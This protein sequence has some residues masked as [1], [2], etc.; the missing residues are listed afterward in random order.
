MRKKFCDFPYRI[1]IKYNCITKIL[2]S[3]SHTPLQF[4]RQKA[5]V[6]EPLVLHLFL[7][8]LWQFF[9]SDILST[10]FFLRLNGMSLKL[11]H[12]LRTVIFSLS[13]MWMWLIK[14]RFHLI[15]ALSISTLFV[16]TF[17]SWTFVRVYISPFKCLLL[18]FLFFFWAVAHSVICKQINKYQ[19]HQIDEI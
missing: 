2:Y 18:C 14:C 3:A 9:F 8:L 11:P 17:F 15:P 13:W 12:F 7:S 16:S 4:M 1:K 5:Y 10:A 6:A 19:Q